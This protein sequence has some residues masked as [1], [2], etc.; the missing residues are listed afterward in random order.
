VPTLLQIPSQQAVKMTDTA[1]SRWESL[2]SGCHGNN[3]AGL[4][5][6]STAF[7]GSELPGLCAAD[8]MQGELKDGW[9]NAELGG[10]CTVP[11]AGQRSTSVEECVGKERI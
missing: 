6:V 9:L 7:H 2:S 5:R 11:V 1:G 3:S 10:G 4:P 8:R